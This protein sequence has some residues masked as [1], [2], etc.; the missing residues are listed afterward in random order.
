MNLLGRDDAR[1]RDGVGLAGTDSDQPVGA[2]S[3][4]LLDA[5]EQ[6]SLEGPEH[7]SKQEGEGVRGVHA[8]ADARAQGRE[9]TEDASLRG[10]RVHHIGPNRPQQ[11][12]ELPDLARVREGGDRAAHGNLVHAATLGLEF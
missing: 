9:P 3:E 4:L 10:M 5:I 2:R 6:A 1:T 8:L 11:A 7:L 12:R